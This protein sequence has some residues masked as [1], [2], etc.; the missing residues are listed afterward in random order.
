M[1]SLVSA[2]RTRNELFLG[3]HNSPARSVG[4]HTSTMAPPPAASSNGLWYDGDRHLMTI[5]PTRSGKGRGLVI[6]NLLMY[7]GPVIVLD[8][9]GELY[10]V[11]SERRRAM[12]QKVIKLDPF[13][14]L[15]PES[16]GLNPFDV[17]DLPNADV[18][19]DSQ[20]MA[21]WLSLGNKGVKDPFWDLNA[22]GVLSGLIGYATISEPE[23]RHLGTVFDVLMADDAAYQMAVILD[24]VG[25]RLNR[26]SYQELAAFL[27][28]PEKETRPSVLG[29]VNSY[30]KPMLS[31]RVR[32]TFAQSSFKLQ[33]VIDGE[34]MSVY[35][36]LPPDKM[37]SHKAILKLWLGTLMKAVI[38]RTS[39]P[40][41]KTI[42][43][44]DECGQIGNF[45]FLETMM[46]LCAGYGLLCWTFWQDLHQLSSA[47]PTTWQTIVNNCAVLQTFGINN[48]MLAANWGVYLRHTADELLM[49]P[50]DEQ[51]VQINGRDEIRC[52]RGD[53]LN[54]PLF[55]G[56]FADNPMY[57]EK[58]KNGDGER[59]R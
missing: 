40:E 50:G 8:P 4:F 44:L 29:T 7:D 13:R 43:F 27:Q 45:P 6:P 2:R 54:D 18:E 28:L 30:I 17:F 9:K 53:Y 20:T 33:E 57:A 25:K 36:V 46:T 59:G 10:R 11:T 19:T 56:L 34:P 48:R 52:R 55:A 1:S 47:Y 12:G 3:W 16:D 38:S 49:L 24:T 22:G 32:S 5:A 23:K 14:V 35:I 58:V 39:I 26:L 41:K 42:L 15:G 51:V 21:D 31:E 37:T